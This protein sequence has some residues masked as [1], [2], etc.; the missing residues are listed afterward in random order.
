MKLERI[1]TLTDYQCRSY[2]IN[3]IKV[4]ASGYCLAQYRWNGGQNWEGRQ[5]NHEEFPTDA[6][7]VMTLF[8]HYMDEIL[9]ETDQGKSQIPNRF[10]TQYFLSLG[11][12]PSTLWSSWLLIL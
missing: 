6:Q 2:V 8:L 11:H 5:W 12:K 1:L 9:D 3:R 7:L 10:S 4:L